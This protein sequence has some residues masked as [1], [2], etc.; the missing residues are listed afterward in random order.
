MH[1]AAAI[2][3][4][5]LT[6]ASAVSAP[7]PDQAGI[8]GLKAKV[9]TAKGDEKGNLCLEVA[10]RQISAADK[11]YNDGKVEE[12]QA[13][14]QDVISYATQA[15]DI[16]AQSGHRLKNSEIAMRKMI[17]RLTDIKHT[18]AS[19]NQPPVQAAIESLERAR[20]ELLNRMFGKKGQ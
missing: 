2:L 1:V 15:G 12:A 14:I 6:V 4:L 10:E 8:E 5:T 16:F 11:L 3:S 17:H 20:T 7:V 19:E 13:A 9:Q 18:L